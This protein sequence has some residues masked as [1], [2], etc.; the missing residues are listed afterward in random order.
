MAHSLMECI[1][2]FMFFISVANHPSE[3]SGVVGCKRLVR[4]W[5]FMRLG[6]FNFVGN[7]C[8]FVYGMW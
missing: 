3:V 1:V 6:S 7:V 4:C 5:V 8:M 2:G